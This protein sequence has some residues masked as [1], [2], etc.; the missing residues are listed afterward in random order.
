MK[1]IAF[2]SAA[3][4][5][6]PK[7]RQLFRSIRRH[8]PEFEVVLALADEPNPALRIDDEPMDRLIHVG[9]LDIPDRQRWVFFHTIVE[10]ATAIKPFVLKR[11]L[12]EPGVSRVLYFDPDM[13]LFSRLDDLLDSLEGGSIALTPHQT[14]PEETIEAVRDNE[15]ASLKHGIYNLGFVGVN[16]ND[17]GR[18]FASWWADRIY[19]FCVADIPNG[20]FTDQRWVDFAPVFFDGVRIL[21]SPRFNVATWNLTTRKLSGD[22]GAG[23]LV[24]GLPLG[25][26]HFTGF[27]S[28][29]HQV[30]AMKN[31]PG[32]D[33]VR[34]LIDWYAEQTRFDHEDPLSRVK[35]AFGCYRDGSPI[36]LLHRRLYRRR[37]DLQQAYPDPFDVT[38]GASLKSWMHHQ[39]PIEYPELFSKKQ[40]G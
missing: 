36:E 27:D 12:T 39:A 21:K 19:H 38:P 16:A 6:L 24:D 17:E 20:L 7:V 22:P 29:A 5:Y 9:E 31:A 14:S 4:N 1:T 25:F 30:M 8:H 11:L 34:S 37:P 18:R 13:V 3:V 33:A 15:I 35:W 26:Y 2:T 32:N 23:F 28:G 40:L 10:L